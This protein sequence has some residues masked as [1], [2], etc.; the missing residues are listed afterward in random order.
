[1]PS[2]IMAA[3]QLAATLLLTF[4]P[5]NG[6]YTALCDWSRIG[7]PDFHGACRLQVMLHRDLNEERH[8]VQPNALI[9]RLWNDFTARPP[10]RLTADYLAPWVCA[11]FAQRHAAEFSA[12]EELYGCAPPLHLICYWR[13]ASLAA[14]CRHVRSSM[15]SFTAS[16]APSVR[17]A[18]PQPP[19]NQLTCA[20]GAL[21]ASPATATNQSFNELICW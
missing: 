1:M 21:I 10:H 16:A 19:V 11:K 8:L 5:I 20:H 13:S 6:V 4:K 2:L 18:P 7:H 12:D 9:M 15:R 3:L 14:R 17:I